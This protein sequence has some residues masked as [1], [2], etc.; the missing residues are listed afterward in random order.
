MRAIFMKQLHTFVTVHKI[1]I[2]ELV[3]FKKLKSC[4]TSLHTKSQT[5]ISK[6]VSIMSVRNLKAILEKQLSVCIF[7]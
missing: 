4:S 2:D 7:N 1:L 6:T 3:I 5:K